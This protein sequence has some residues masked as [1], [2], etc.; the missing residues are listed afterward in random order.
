MKKNLKSTVLALALAASVTGA[1][2]SDI[3]HAISG[4]KLANY[5]WQR[6][7]RN[8]TTSGL[9]SLVP[10]IRISQVVQARKSFAR[11]VLLSITLNYLLLSTSMIKQNAWQKLFCQASFTDSGR[12]GSG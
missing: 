9:P 4:K 12:K 2:A 7:N 11:K 5:T 3:A 6:Y 10:R 1:F 8:Q